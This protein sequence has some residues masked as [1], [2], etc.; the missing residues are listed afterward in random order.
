[1]ELGFKPRQSVFRVYNE[2]QGKK[3]KGHTKDIFYARFKTYYQDLN[4]YSWNIMPLQFRLHI[5][6]IEHTMLV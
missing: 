6:Y 1:M 3:K 2:Q 4:Y 5:P